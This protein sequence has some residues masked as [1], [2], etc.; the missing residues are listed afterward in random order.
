MFF[1]NID[2]TDNYYR[3]G[4]F[5]LLK[6]ILA[7]HLA[8]QPA[9]LTKK[10]NKKTRIVFIDADSDFFYKT[11]EHAC[12]LKKTESLII[13][14]V[15]SCQNK[16]LLR[17]VIPNTVSDVFYK[18]DDKETITCKIRQT[19]M[20]YSEMKT[21]LTPYSEESVYAVF[22]PLPFTSHESAVLELFKRGFSGNHRLW[23]K[24]KK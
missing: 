10:L 7:K 9:I 13:F 18:T 24:M 3:Y 12:N 8:I 1:C 20:L 11:F 6:E 5:I 14:I 23:V 15:L 22:H 2:T 4:L 16:S 21:P 17:N 19:L